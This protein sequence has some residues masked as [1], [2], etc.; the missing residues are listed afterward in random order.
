MYILW[1]EQEYDDKY[2]LFIKNTLDE[3]KEAYIYFCQKNID[4]Y[5]F[6]TINNLKI[7]ERDLDSFSLYSHDCTF[8]YQNVKELVHDKPIYIFTF[9]EDGE[10]QDYHNE[11]YFELSNSKKK[12]LE[13][14]TEYFITESKKTKKKDIKEML[15]NLDTFGKYSIPYGRTYVCDMEIYNYTP[16]EL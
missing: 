16:Y 4:N 9:K 15:D 12:L 1:S 10:G 5:D 11:I 8:Y 2:I 13:R 7:K 3:L 6:D 14:A